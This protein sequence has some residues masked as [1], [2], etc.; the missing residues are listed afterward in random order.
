MDFIDD[1]FGPVEDETEV[2]VPTEVINDRGMTES[3]ARQ[4][5]IAAIDDE[6]YEEHAAIIAAVPGAFKITGKETEPPPDW[7]EEYGKDNAWVRFRIAQASLQAGKNAPVALTIAKDMMKAISKARDM[8]KGQGDINMTIQVT[9]IPMP[10]LE[11]P[12][13]VD[14]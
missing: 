12:I 9:G 5:R 7:I 6:L 13:E 10:A 3:Q 2:I 14:E 8:R 11:A 1:M 4:E